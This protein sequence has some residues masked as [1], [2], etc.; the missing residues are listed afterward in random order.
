MV[1]A[2]APLIDLGNG[3]LGLSQIAAAMKLLGMTNGIGAQLC[4]TDLHPF[5][6]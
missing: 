4:L 2:G 3:D 5:P 1:H 6:A